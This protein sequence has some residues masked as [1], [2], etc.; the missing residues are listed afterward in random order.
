MTAGEYFDD[1]NR[2]FR[3][4]LY[5]A[6]LLRYRQASD[7]GMATPLLHYN[8]GVA[9][10]R[11]GQHLRARDELLRALDAPGLRV[12]AQYNLGLNAYKLGQTDEA[13][14]WFRLA[15][16]QQQSPKI[17][18]YA[19]VAVARILGQ[20]QLEDPVLLEQEK[21]RKQS[22]FARLELRARV[23]F[24]TD[25][26]VFRAPGDDY[27][28]F[29]DPALPV[30]RPEAVTGAFMPFTLSA[31]YKINAYENE[32]FFGAYRLAGRYYQDEELDNANQ[33]SHEASFGSDYSFLHEEKGRERRLYSAFTVAQ[34]DEVYFDPD[35]GAAYAVDGEL[36]DE[37]MN[38]L[39]YG[40]ELTFRQSY[41]KLAFGLNIKGQ[42]WNYEDT[43]LVPEYDH[44]FFEF[45]LLGQYRFT[46]TSLLR[47]TAEKSSRRYGERRAYNRDGEQ[48]AANQTLRY[49]FLEL[50]ITAR[51][52][53]TRKMWFGVDYKRTDRSDKF[54]G[55]NDY[56]RDSYGVRFHWDIGQRFSFEANGAYMLYNFPRAY[57]FNDPALPRKTLERV[58]VSFEAS[59]RMTRHLYLV[60]D[61]HHTEKVSNDTRISY[62]RDQYTLGVRWAQ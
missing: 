41:D 39:R 9:H 4:D 12:A 15:R 38:Y 5:W 25:S 23:S 49:D 1:G 16:D 62:E 40:P 46:S 27:I 20:Q 61:G 48:L 31:K 54:E 52:R 3:D 32:G 35:D 56:I 13:L 53:I 19:R 45:G 36:I 43:E 37:R 29:S 50:G 26:N 51:Q 55:Y 10:Y 11:A 7:A 2:L 44:E 18:A 42:L 58:N 59:F 33:Y 17:A 24:G 34:H 60:L 28:D 14:R 21:E 47:I 30:I 8:T 22:D 6:A 57:A